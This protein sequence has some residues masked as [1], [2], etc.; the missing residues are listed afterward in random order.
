LTTLTIGVYSIANAYWIWGGVRCVTL[1]V[2]M[3]GIGCEPY[4]CG[5]FL[6]R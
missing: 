2:E 5:V 1:A 6:V 3:G 4:L